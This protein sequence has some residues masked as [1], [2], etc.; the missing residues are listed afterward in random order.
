MEAPHGTDILHVIGL[1]V[2]AA[3]VLAYVAKLTRQ[4]LLLAYIGAGVLI[5]PIGLELIAD[6]D[7]HLIERLA[8]LGL[9]FLLFIVGLEIDVKKLIDSGK[10]A[11][12]TT[13][14]Q[15]AGSAVLGFAAAYAL[16]YRGLDAAY[17]GVAVAFSSTM[18]VV[19]LLADRFE[20]DTAPGHLTL[21]ILLVQDVLAI[22]V[23]AIQPKIGGGGEGSAL[24]TI[25]LAG[26]KGL[27]LLV[28]TLG[29]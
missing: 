6:K 14:V 8:E 22:V 11:S 3:T 17:L 19:K 24:V 16:G 29:I 12:V 21:G 18:I 9:A 10:V 25:G 28:G 27:A 15:V 2:V 26:L 20:L 7:R 1:C 5:G 4:P 23:L 13:I